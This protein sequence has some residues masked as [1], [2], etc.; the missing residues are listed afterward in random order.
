[1][2][3][4]ARRAEPLV[5]LQRRVT[6]PAE[7]ARRPPHRGAAARSRSI[8]APS[9]TSSSR[10][11]AAAWRRAGGSTTRG[12]ARAPTR[13]SSTTR[14]RRSAPAAPLGETS[15][16]GP[17]NSAF[18]GVT[19]LWNHPD[20]PYPGGCVPQPSGPHGREARGRRRSWPR[21]SIAAARAR[22][23]GSRCRRPS[24]PPTSWATSTSSQPTRRRPR[25]DAATPR[26]VRRAPRRL[27]LRRRR[28]LDRDRRR[29]PTPTGQRFRDS[30][31]GPTTQLRT[32]ADARSA[33]RARILDRPRRRLDAPA[34]RRSISPR[35]LQ[36][37][38]R[39]RHA[40]MNGDDHRADAAP[41]R[42]RR[43]RHRRSPRDRPRA[44]HR[45]TRSA[46]RDSDARPPARPLLGEHTHDVLEPLARPG[47]RRRWR[48]RC[49][50]TAPAAESVCA[51]D[52]RA[53]AVRSAGTRRCPSRGRRATPPRSALRS[54]C[55]R[56]RP[57][58]ARTPPHP[59]A[60]DHAPEAQFSP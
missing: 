14:R 53:R 30:P 1:M 4:R 50:P 12:V 35:R 45:P 40:V 7:R 55:A 2:T 18:A 23:S 36:N 15:A 16:F 44:P 3:R 26:S 21:S 38:R 17:L 32:L 34:A 22:A 9:P 29:R 24:R 42:T 37:R 5:D 41:R 48:Q 46:S 60:H 58:P 54:E 43:H 28:S 59:R 10:T 20:A 57:P 6:R 13:T 56:R 49:S 51:L 39:L 25:A 11:T 33:A 19:W 47:R 52:S 8:R 27:S 31:A